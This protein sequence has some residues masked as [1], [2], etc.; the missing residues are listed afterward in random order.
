MGRGGNRVPRDR[1]PQVSGPGR[2]SRRSDN[3]P[4]D[5]PRVGDSEDL[6]HG[7]RQ[8]LEAAQRQ[9]GIPRAPAPS[10]QGLPPVPGAGP[11]GGAGE[12]PP[13]LFSRDSARPDEPITAGLPFGPGAGP[14]ALTQE[15][16]D[17]QEVVLQFL[18]DEFADEAAY[19]MLQEKRGQQVAP[20]PMM[21]DLPPDDSDLDLEFTEEV[22][23]DEDLDEQDL[24]MEEELPPEEG[25]TE[26]PVEVP[27]PQAEAG[28]EVAEPEGED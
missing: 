23:I 17:D 2:F 26:A 19:N 9:V 21:D 25:F 11:T 13:H 6:Q 27:T 3:Q 1:T 12:L 14:E 20:P 8:R 28:E 5:V 24:L 18:I 4:V 7:D 16:A 22:P 10:P 15:P